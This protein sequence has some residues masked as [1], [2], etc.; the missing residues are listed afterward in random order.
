MKTLKQRF[1]EAI[2]KGELGTVEDRGVVVTLK[3]FSDYFDDIKTQYVS[4]FLPAAVIETGQTSVT[5]T[6]F[7]FRLSKG[8]YL[9][10]GD[11]IEAYRLSCDED[12]LDDDPDVNEPL[13]GCFVWC[14]RLFFIGKRKRE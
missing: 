11:A 4:S 5:N 14:W 6:K 2:I 1:F 10:H 12:S 3:E 9:V 7:L 13:L 8:V